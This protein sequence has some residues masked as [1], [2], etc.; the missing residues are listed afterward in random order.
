MSEERDKPDTPSNLID[1]TAVDWSKRTCDI[2]AELEVLPTRVSLMR[3]RHAPDTL[4]KIGKTDWS[5]VDWSLT[6]K[7]LQE[8]YDVTKQC[9]A[10]RRA[11]HAPHTLPRRKRVYRR[12][13]TPTVYE[14]EEDEDGLRI[15]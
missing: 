9:V 3:A 13:S 6:N 2:A 1:W 7:Q 10:N 8:K 5:Q 11:K 4:A 14:E 15:Y 12:L